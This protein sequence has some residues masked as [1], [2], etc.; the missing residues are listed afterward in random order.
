MDSLFE[1]YHTRICLISTISLFEAAIKNFIKRLLDTK[2]I[3]TQPK[4][5][6]KRRL[7]WVFSEV[8]HSNYGTPA[9]IARI[10]EL[11]LQLDHARRIRNLWMHNNG[12]FEKR[13]KTDCLKVKRHSPI[14]DSAYKN[15]QPL[16]LKSK[17]FIN[18]Y[19]SHL[20]LLHQIHNQIQIKYFDQ[21]KSYSYK[22]MGKTIEWKRLLVGK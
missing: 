8:E 11:C 4:D 12:L 19:R 5:N 1:P 6:Y 2:K 14:I 10:S 18:M 3:N 17:D 9:M 22:A 16:I 20:E 13:Y 21:K 7:E 15:K